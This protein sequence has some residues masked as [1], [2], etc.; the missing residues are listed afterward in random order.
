MKLRFANI[1]FMIGFSKEEIILA[2]DDIEQ[3]NH[4]NIGRAILKA[5][6]TPC[7]AVKE[8]IK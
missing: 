4:A 8:E 2:I 7:I 3:N 6:R 5:H 1:M